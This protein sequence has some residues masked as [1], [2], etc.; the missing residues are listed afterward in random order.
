[1]GI[2]C[3]GDGVDPR[4]T[5]EW[6]LQLVKKCSLKVQDI[7]SPGSN[8]SPKFNYEQCKYLADKLASDLTGVESFLRI[9]RVKCGDGDMTKHADIFKFFLSLALEVE[10]FIQGCCK[11][12]WIQAAL[13]LANM[14][15]HVTLLGFN[16]EL[17]RV[18][19]LVNN[20]EWTATQKR[21]VDEVAQMSELE[22]KTV[23]TGAD[24]DMKILLK[25]LEDAKMSPSGK[26]RGEDVLLAT[27][28]LERLKRGIS[29]GQGS[30]IGESS[31]KVPTDSQPS[32][33]S[34]SDDRRSSQIYNDLEQR[35]SLGKGSFGS[36]VHEAI[37]FGAQVA[38][39]TFFGLDHP[40]FSKEMSFLER[41]FHSN[42]MS[43]FCWGQNQRKC[44]SFL[45]MEFM[46]G[47]LFALIQERMRGDGSDE[48]PP[49][50]IFEAIDLMSQI[51]AGMNYL[52]ENRVLHR[53]LKSGNIF[54]KRVKDPESN[55]EYVHVKVGDFGLSKTKERSRTYSE[56]EPNMGTTRWMAPE[57]MPTNN[58]LL[59]WF[60]SFLGIQTQRLPFK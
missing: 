26:S 10:T 28:L 54:F 29:I 11:D 7:I 41:C 43:L 22:V 15:E 2:K 55:I 50:N 33:S 46:D 57:L 30:N 25:M 40:D 35:R 27:V 60:W 18:V 5:P 20:D 8:T 38:M 31:S 21:T 32:E 17:C 51:A 47:D 23:K 37:W 42:V 14:C 34:R 49:F 12:A 19:F 13:T 3:V 58:G 59:G 9:F 45:V 1:V 48:S 6:Y 36:H 4:K 56:L 44:T 52:Y 24:R 16:L 39:K 53:D